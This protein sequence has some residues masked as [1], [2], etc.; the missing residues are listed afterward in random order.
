MTEIGFGKA[1]EGHHEDRLLNKNGSFNARKL[2][3]HWWDSMSLYDSLLT[4]PWKRF[5]L[6]LATIYFISNLLFALLFTSLGPGALGG[7]VDG[8]L[9]QR[10]VNCFFFSFQTFATI[11]YGVIHPNSTTANIL[12]AIES[13]AGILEFSVFTGLMFARFSRPLVRVVFSENALIAPYKDKMSLQFRLMNLRH[14]QLL[15]P[16]ARVVFTLVVN[17]D[18]KSSRQYY[19]IKLQIETVMFIPLYWTVNH[20]I[21]ESSPLYNLSRE[22][23]LGAQPEILISISAID[24][25]SAEAVYLKTSYKGSEIVYGAVFESMYVDEATDSA[26]VSFDRLSKFRMVGIQIFQSQP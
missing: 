15:D 17:K 16:R 23:I 10:F 4:M 1:A 11:G 25:T 19:P 7:V 20:I 24:E 2:G 6:T 9:M 8:S 18:G 12:V 5:F 13:L 21:D 26:T 14:S 3:I 22:D